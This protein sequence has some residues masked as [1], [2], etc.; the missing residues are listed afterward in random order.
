MSPKTCLAAALVAVAIALHG[1]GGHVYQSVDEAVNSICGGSY[2]QASCTCCVQW[3]WASGLVC[4]RGV[5]N[6]SDPCDVE[7]C[8][9]KSSCTE[10][11]EP[12][13]CFT[14]HNMGYCGRQYWSEAYSE[15]CGN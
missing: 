3:L 7:G 11:W 14:D 13:D 8:T 9:C 6:G 1:C 5:A 10:G 2:C 4:S 12:D 15:T